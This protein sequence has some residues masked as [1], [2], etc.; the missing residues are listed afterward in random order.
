VAH[1]TVWDGRKETIQKAVTHSFLAM[2]KP[3]AEKPESKKAAPMIGPFS[4]KRK[5]RSRRLSGK[6]S[7]WQP[8]SE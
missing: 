7:L 6:I 4:A 5:I 3:Q 1:T 2:D 8:R